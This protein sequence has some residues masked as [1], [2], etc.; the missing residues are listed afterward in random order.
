MVG[1]VDFDT[2]E[3]DAEG[4]S[5]WAFFA[6]GRGKTEYSTVSHAEGIY[7]WDTDGRRYLDGSSGAGCANIGHGNEHVRR[8]MIE[9]SSKVTYVLRS[10]FAT[11]PNMRL[12]KSVTE[13]AGPGFDQA[14][15]V[16][17]GSESIE[18]ALKL[19]RQYAFAIGEGS[20]WKVLA[21]NPSYHGATLGAAAVTGDRDREEIIGEM[22][23]VMPK[24]PTPFTYR[25]PY[26]H[27][28]DSHATHCAERLEEQILK[29]GPESVLA[30]IMEPVGGMATG[31][32]VSPDHYYK[33]VREICDRY[34]ILLIYDEV[35][36]GTGRT[37]AFLAAHH[38]PD[39][40][41]DLVAM[42]KGIGSGYTPLGAILAPNKVA[43]AVAGSGGFA[44]GHTYAGNPLSAAIG[45]AVLEELV[46]LDL[47]EN[48]TRMGVLLRERLVEVMD[49]SSVI[50]DVRGRGLLNAI[51]IVADRKTKAMFPLELQASSR[52]GEI[53]R[54]VG[55]LMFSRR[56]AG[57]SF[58]EWLLAAP[59]LIITEPQVEEY[60]GLVAEMVAIF[61]REIGR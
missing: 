28:A 6:G 35:L 14:F 2:L 39:A 1:H 19:A 58:G 17:G 47:M 49:N 15:L 53:G 7:F 20:R 36:S 33:A 40:M 23:Q 42:A 26:G 51:E 52:I 29:E 50:G 34:G 59:P 31:A 44:H 8:A 22:M 4:A 48:A 12:I 60:V 45:V 38:W 55:L 27:D 21:R 32:V 25:V 56:H 9:Q 43:D 18:A 30:F 37:G 46:R 16:S 57:G 10:A 41:P 5:P 54:E 24:I 3:N 11:E 61:E 13:L